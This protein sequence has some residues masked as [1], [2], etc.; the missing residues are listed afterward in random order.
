M[1]YLPAPR[2]AVASLGALLG[3]PTP[4]A[5]FKGLALWHRLKQTVPWPVVGSSSSPE[6]QRFIFRIILPFTWMIMLISY[7]PSFYP[8]HSIIL[9]YQCFCRYNTN[10]ISSFCIHKLLN[11]QFILIMISLPNSCSS[12]PLVFSSEQTFSFFQ[13]WQVL[14]LFAP[15]FPQSISLLSYLL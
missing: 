9:S 3:G 1:L 6:Y 10:S 11:F 12:T 8:F 15:K 2:A 14:V 7:L 13:Q 4:S 5:L